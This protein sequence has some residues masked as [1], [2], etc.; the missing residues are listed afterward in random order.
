M[1]KHAEVTAPLGTLVYFCEPASPWQRASNQNTN[2]L[3]RQYF[4]KGHDLSTVEPADVLLATEEINSRPRAVLDWSSA[5]AKFASYHAA[6]AKLDDTARVQA[7][8]E[9]AGTSTLHPKTTVL[10]A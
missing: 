7:V 1:A 2:G 10:E 3:L 9:P 6:A 4:R 8:T 5:S